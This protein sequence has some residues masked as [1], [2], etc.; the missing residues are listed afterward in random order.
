MRV[1]DLISRT[2]LDL[3]CKVDANQAIFRLITVQCKKMIMVNLTNPS[4]NESYIINVTETF[5]PYVNSYMQSY[6]DNGLISK[7]T[8]KGYTCWELYPLRFY[9]F[10]GCSSINK[11]G[12]GT[13]SSLILIVCIP[14]GSWILYKSIVCCYHS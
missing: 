13:V 10:D 8:F 3:P 9:D 12:K 14:L 6:V 4:F 5:D 2:M 7:N 11:F 1:L